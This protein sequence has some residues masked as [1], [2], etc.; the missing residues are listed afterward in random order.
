MCQPGTVMLQ[1]NQKIRNFETAC[2]SGINKM[3]SGC[4]VVL[5]NVGLK[6]K[7]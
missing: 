4:F 6:K 5:K 2:Q 7:H 3:L 1:K